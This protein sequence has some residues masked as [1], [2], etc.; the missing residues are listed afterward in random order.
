MGFVGKAFKGCRWFRT[1][2]SRKEAL[3]WDELILTKEFAWDP[4]IKPAWWQD[5]WVLHGMRV[6]SCVGPSGQI[7]LH[8]LGQSGIHILGGSS[9][10]LELGACK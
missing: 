1:R 4:G 5:L 6:L 9:L 10:R 3:Q 7:F 2:W 8:L